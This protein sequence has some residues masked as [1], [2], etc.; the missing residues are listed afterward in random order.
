MNIERNNFEDY[1]DPYE[2]KKLSPRTKVVQ[3]FIITTCF[4]FFV[5]VVT[6]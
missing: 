5:Y 2:A 1:P 4:C 3:G 6:L